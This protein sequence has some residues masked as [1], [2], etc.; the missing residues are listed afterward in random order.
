[1]IFRNGDDWLFDARQDW[2]VLLNRKLKGEIVF[3]ESPRIIMA[4]AE[5][6]EIQDGLRRLRQSSDSVESYLAS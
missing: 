3:P 4:I 2:S 1:M 6:L 5:R